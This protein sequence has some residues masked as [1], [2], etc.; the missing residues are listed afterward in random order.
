MSFTKPDLDVIVVGA[1]FAGLYMLHRLRRQGLAAKILESADGVGGT[2]YWNRYPGARCDI[3]SVDY[4]YSFDKELQTDWQWSERYAK[5]SEILEYL[6]HVADRFDLRRDI[7]FETRVA[8][9]AWDDAAGLWRIATEDGET[10][11]CRHY[12]MATGCLSVPKDNE[13]DGIEAFGGEVY[14]TGRWPHREVDFTGKRV[15]VIGTGSSGIQAIPEIAK[16]AKS[17]TVFQRTPN[18]SI[19]ARHG[20]V[21]DERIAAFRKDPEAYRQ[22]ARYSKL[23]V[24][25]PVAMEQTKTVSDEE[26]RRRYEHVWRTGELQ[27]MFAQFAD[28]L[29]DKAANDTMAAFMHE[30]IREIVD[31]PETA[32]A[33]CP[34]DHPIASKRPCLDDGY[35]ATFILPHVSLVDL[36]RDPIRGIAATGVETAGGLHEFDVIVLATGFDAMTGAVVRV[37]IRGRDGLSLKE[38]WADG[39]Q[40]YM[41]LM[42]AG[43]PNLFLITGP[44]SP[45][46]LSNMAVSIEQHVEMIDDLLADMK[47]SGREVVEPSAIAEEVWTR[48]N[49]DAGNLTL[50][51]TAN[52]WY[53]GANV[54]GKPRRFLPFIGGVDSYRRA[55]DDLKAAD[56]MGLHFRGES[57]ARP[58]DRI[59]RPFRPDVTAMLEA[60]AEAGLPPLHTLPPAELR[61]TMAAVGE[62]SPKGPEVGEV[63]DGTFPGADGT[64][65]R[66]RLYRPDTPGPHPLT[67]YF[68]GGGWVIGSEVSDDAFCRDLC[69]RSNS[70][71]VSCD[72]RHAPE[73]RFP[74]AV[75]DAL[76]ALDWVAKEAQALG[77]APG[78][79]AVAGW[80]AGGNLAAVATQHARDHGGPALS[81]Q[82]L[83]TPVTDSDFSRPS[84]VEN[85]AGPVLTRELMDYFWDHY[86]DP[87][88]RQDPRVAPIR[89]SSLAGLPP[90][91]VVVS[92]FD[93]LRDEGIAYAE[94]MK[95]AGV[96]V[97]LLVGRGHMHTSY[98]AVDVILSGAE[99]RAQMAEALDGFFE[100]RRH[101]AE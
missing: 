48:Y 79:L 96:P 47:A 67:L 5:Q 92:Q 39:P 10:L 27:P 23:G 16:Q 64:E 97:T 78:K 66:W 95:A 25:G 4:S 1:G 33:L 86:V 75:E 61:A 31:D 98:S 90:A 59:V 100:P 37:D 73:A 34:T 45:S 94:A 12:V 99:M 41:G 84:Y 91:M 70:L 51:V 19:P 57:G 42:T 8:Q 46:V 50:H 87:A 30:K 15:G 21:S 38:K 74:A 11:T 7:R 69:V 2:W 22:A 13:F 81:G 54:P 82:L 77:G 83:I 89:A 26:R 43:F 93:P 62:Q 63:R 3:L 44:G 28:T 24:P 18:F 85:A 88:D 65:L 56:W 6:N 68:H 40:T 49:D 72:Y 55:C 20:P 36:R 71:I 53:M 9:A 52:S 58:D 29:F 35:Y 76:A 32:E 17:V 80:S 14:S 101:A 60:M